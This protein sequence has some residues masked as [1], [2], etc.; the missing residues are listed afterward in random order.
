MQ[1]E[2]CNRIVQGISAKQMISSGRDLYSQ[3]NEKG[4]HDLDL[5]KSLFTINRI[6]YISKQILIISSILTKVKQ[7]R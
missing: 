5:G 7:L 2:W 6:E 4:C 3:E 1:R